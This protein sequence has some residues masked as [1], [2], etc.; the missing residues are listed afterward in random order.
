MPS[1]EFDVGPGFASRNQA[2]KYHDSPDCT[3]VLPEGSGSAV[4]SIVTSNAP[5]PSAVATWSR[6][7][8]IGRRM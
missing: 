8:P 4:V 1:V 2:W 6:N 7:R 5:A 3:D